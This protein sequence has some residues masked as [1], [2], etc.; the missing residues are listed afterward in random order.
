[1]SYDTQTLAGVVN[2]LDQFNPFILAMFFPRAIAFDT[3]EIAIDVVAPDMKLAPFVS[4]MV[5]GKAIKADGFSTRK[6]KPAYLKPKHVVDPERVLSRR[7]GE[8]IGGAISAGARHN[9]IVGDILDT[10]RKQIIR[11]QEWMAVQAMLTGKVTVSGE[12]Y[13]TVEVD[14]Q[15]AAGN[16]VTLA[17]ND[18]WSDTVNA[19]PLDDFEEWNDIAAAPITDFIMDSLSF[20]KLMKFQVVK[21]LLDTRRG[22]DSNLEM[23]PDN[24]K[25]VSFKGWLGSFRIWVYKGY[26][27]DAAGAKVNYIP[28]NTV[29]GASSAV[30]GVRSF[31]AILDAA[32]GYQAME[33]F[34]KNWVNE[35][36]SVEYIMTQSGP[37]MIPSEPDAVVV[38]TID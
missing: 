20:K 19:T 15:R 11:R 21:D 29:I 10:Q 38:A 4:P 3:S 28:D 30:E 22:S 33:M 12:D 8:V 18:V 6:F 13:K 35:D 23:G 5:A 7:A 37:L 26:Y 25:W 34:P 36:P 31:G 16:T 32:A 17:G 9:A 14:F 1:M 2:G 27:K 24:A